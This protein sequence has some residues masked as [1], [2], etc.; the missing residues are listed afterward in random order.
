M[1]E[2]SPPPALLSGLT[3]DQ[4]EVA[5]RKAER[6]NCSANQVIVSIGK[7]ATRLFQLTKG[8]AKFYRV[9]NEGNEILMW[10]LSSGDVF[11][12]GALLAR[13]WRYIGTAQAVSQC[14]MLVWTRESIQSL[15]STIHETMTVNSLHIAMNAL[16]EYGDRMVEIKTETAE[17]RLARTLLQLARRTGTVQPNG[18]DVTIRNE[19]LGALANVGMFT[20]SRLMQKW[21]REGLTEKGRGKVRI[22]S[23]E[24]LFRS[25][26]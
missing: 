13:P 6:R 11:G 23:P 25:L 22:L 3:S 24:N 21:E 4:R 16:A 15:P 1:R 17:Q 19:D 9:T 10:W 18:V 7:P 26:R 5:I 8:T 14:E 2:S 20:V 12:I